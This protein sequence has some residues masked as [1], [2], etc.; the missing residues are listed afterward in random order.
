M[1]IRCGITFET[2]VDLQEM[3][4]DEQTTARVQAHLEAGCPECAARLAQIARTFSALAQAERIHAPESA[5][6]RARALYR[7]R[8]RAPERPSL[9]ARLLFDGRGQL[10]LAGA[11]GASAEAFHL[12]YQA[13]PYDID[14]WQEL[15]EEGGWYIMGQA[16]RSEGE[17]VTP[18]TVTLVADNGETRTATQEEGE[19]HL[20]AVEAGVYRLE[21][22]LPDA[23]IIVPDLSIGA[24]A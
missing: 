11:R 16:L 1:R 15:T 8:F 14:L 20:D 5:L 18:E 19:F 2:L 6:E 7:E 9:L 24:G 10:A 3:R 17:A 12:V 21:V 22:N 4:L 13:K 23:Q